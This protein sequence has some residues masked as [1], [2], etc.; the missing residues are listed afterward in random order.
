MRGNADTEK[1][2]CRNC[3]YARWSDQGGQC[4]APALDIQSQPIP[5]SAVFLARLNVRFRLS[6]GQAFSDRKVWML[7]DVNEPGFE[8]ELLADPAEE[9][10]NEL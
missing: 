6:K 10:W 9:V 2:T 4:T 5:L 8:R 3:Q 7:R 1:R